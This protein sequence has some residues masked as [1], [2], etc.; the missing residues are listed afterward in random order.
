MFAN[1]SPTRKLSIFRKALT[2]QNSATGVIVQRVP[3]SHLKRLLLSEDQQ[4]P[5]VHAIQESKRIFARCKDK[6]VDIELSLHAIADEYKRDGTQGNG[7]VLLAWQMPYDTSS[8]RYSTPECVGIATM[9]NFKSNNNFSTLPTQMS[10]SDYNA[11]HPY[12]GKYLY[13]DAMCSKRAGVGMLLVLH[14]YQ[15]A[16]MRKTHGLIALSFSTSSRKTPESKR[17]FEKLGFTQLI[18][19]ANFKFQ[20][21]GTWFVKK[22]KDIDLSGFDEDSV[23]VCVRRGLTSKSE[24]NLISRCQ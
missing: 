6:D 5:L 22:S 4:D 1:Q 13:I 15:Y 18:P 21:Y 19:K 24:D 3:A 23:H 11:L 17:I 20:V 2:F 7:G 9:C 16:V 12:F 14:A 10:T 8:K